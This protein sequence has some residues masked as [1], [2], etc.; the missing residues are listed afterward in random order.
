MCR[1]VLVAFCVAAYGILAS[2][3]GWPI[4]KI[5]IGLLDVGLLQIFVKNF[6]FR[7][8][9]QN[10]REAYLGAFLWYFWELW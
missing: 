10:F 7:G 6:I 8:I 9:L 1:C 2:L 4:A 5:M 3:A